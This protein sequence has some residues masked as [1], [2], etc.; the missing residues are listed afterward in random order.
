MKT[1][2]ETYLNSLSEYI[3]ILGIE[4][5]DIT[6]MP[7]LTRFKNLKELYIS[8]NKLTSLSCTLLPRS[9]EILYCSKNKL[10]FLP[11]LTRFKN[12]KQ[13]YC[14][15]NKLS[16]LPNIL[17]EGL[18]I[19][20][21]SS[22]KLTSLPDLKRLKNLKELNCSNNQ[23][24]CLPTKLPLSLETLFCFDNRL[25]YF[26]ILPE[27][28]VNFYYPNNPIC[29]ILDDNNNSLIKIKQNIKIVNNFRYLY[30]SLLLKKQFRKWLW[31]KVR[32]KQ[33]MDKYHPSYLV[34][35]L[36]EN[37]DLDEFLNNW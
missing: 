2:I 26:P 24:N 34:E 21:C 15:I 37:T 5:E 29:N 3:L 25:N 14:S 4:G 35:N 17:P 6:S 22:N 31:E 36:D 13:L 27:N 33:I 30:Y 18:E 1:K 16:S 7:D 23:L 9:V 8:D 10:S 20:H 19:L 12:L 11:E 28:I 32:E